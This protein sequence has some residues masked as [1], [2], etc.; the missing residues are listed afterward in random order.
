M[1]DA[2][3]STTSQP[4]KTDRGTTAQRLRKREDWLG[5]IA[6]TSLFHALFDSLP[7]LHFF[8]KNRAGELMFLSRSIRE[9]YGIGQDADVIGLTDFDINPGGM[10]QS[11]VEDDARIYAT[12]EPILGRVEL[13]WDMRGI[14][15]WYAVTKLPIHSRDG[16]IIGVMGVSQP[17]EDRAKLAE[18]WSEIAAAVRHVREKYRSSV[19]V[20]TLARLTR[21]SVRQL[22]RKFQTVLGV[23][24]QEFLIK[25][26]VLAAS[27]ALRES[28]APLAEIAAEC[29]F[30]DQSSFTEQFRRH[31]GQTP[32]QF[33]RSVGGI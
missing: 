30:Y 6:P 10:A 8:A 5:E 12:G 28:D 15:D 13:W 4:P 3:P 1:P 27:R 17:Y 20:S 24:P 16:E 31:V 9:R 7:G 26:R 25:T 29:G 23:T 18:P 14:P 33:R 32:R 19:D 11:Y 22:Q 2:T 21:L